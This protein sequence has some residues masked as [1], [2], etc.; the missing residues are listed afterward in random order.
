MPA[1][2]YAVV[3]RG[4]AAEATT[5][6]LAAELRRH[7]RCCTSCSALASQRGEHEVMLL[8]G[9]LTVEAAWPQQWPLGAII[10]HL[11]FGAWLRYAAAHAALQSTAA[12]AGPATFNAKCFVGA[13]GHLCTSA[14]CV[15][16]CEIYIQLRITA[17]LHAHAH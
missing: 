7:M 15:G 13:R 3:C 9:R 16:G 5:D 14:D 1:A 17:S 4:R 2:A 6:C 12:I 8:A 11:V 10:L